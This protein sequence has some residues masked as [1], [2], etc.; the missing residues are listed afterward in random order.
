VPTK[1]A[2]LFAFVLWARRGAGLSWAELGLDRARLPDGIR[3]GGLTALAIAAVILF[4]V[5]APVTQSFFET[6]SIALDSTAQHL[7]MP[8]VIIPV[9]TALFEETLFRGVLLGVLL[10]TTS[11]GWAVAVSSV[12]FGLWHIPPALHD[13]RGHGVGAAAG[14]VV[15]VVAFTTVAGALFALLRL[16]SGSLAAPF[17]AHAGTNVSAYLAALAVS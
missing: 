10:R 4:S 13:A 11:R 15:G 7:L 9:G 3:L 14:A 16:R 2:I 6:R 5:G 17:L 1:L 8:I 12:L